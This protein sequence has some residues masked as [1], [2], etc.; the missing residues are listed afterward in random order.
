[1]WRLQGCGPPVAF[2]DI[3]LV[4]ETKEK[5]ILAAQLL[6][7]D[8]VFFSPLNKGGRGDWQASGTSKM[9]ECFTSALT[10]KRMPPPGEGCPKDRKGAASM[11]LKDPRC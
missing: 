1:M 11:E 7:A 2:G 8:I 10:L 4:G 3:P 6:A 5:G 9:F